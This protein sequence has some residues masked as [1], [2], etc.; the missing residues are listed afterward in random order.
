VR[1]DLDNYRCA[2]TWLLEHNRC[3]EA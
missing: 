2:L 3:A 1:D